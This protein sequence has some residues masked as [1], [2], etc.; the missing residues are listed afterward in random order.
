MAECR[1]DLDIDSLTIYETQITN[2]KGPIWLDNSRVAAGKSCSSEIENA[3][4]NISPIG[5]ANGTPVSVTGRLHKGAVEFD[6]KMNSGGNNEYSLMA[7][8]TDGCLSTTCREFGVQSDNIDGHSFAAI[9]L[10][11]DYSGIHSQR[12]QGIIQLRNAKIYELPVFL[13]FLKILN[14]RELS[15]TAFDSANIDFTV[16]GENID[17]NRM[18]FIGDAI[19]LFGN[20]R[21]NLDRD[22]DLNFYSIMGRNR[23]NIPLLSAL[24]HAS[25][26][27]MLWIQVIG[28]LENPKTIR[29][30][31]PQLNDTLRQL[32]EPREK[33]GLANRFERPLRHSSANLLNQRALQSNPSNTFR[34]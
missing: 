12:G 28:T 2:I 16:Q 10:E 15:P 23:Y 21:M 34:R 29:H 9:R 6:A 4:S 30:P 13:R 33:S 5:N 24:Y 31:F 20:G 26:Q 18:E 19:S 7:T 27:K 8:L 11:G 14:I 22:I 3:N 17:F 25:S 32:F 1:G